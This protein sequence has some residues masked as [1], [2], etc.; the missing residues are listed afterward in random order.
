MSQRRHRLVLAQTKRYVFVYVENVLTLK[1]NKSQIF[2]L[3]YLFRIGV[4]KGVLIAPINKLVAIFLVRTFV[5]G[6]GIPLE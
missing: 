2:R 6:N 3:V 4:Q 5:L 1:D